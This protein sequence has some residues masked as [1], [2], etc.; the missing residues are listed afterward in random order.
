VSI[1]YKTNLKLKP[2]SVEQKQQLMARIASVL[3]L[4]NRER[5]QTEG[6][7]VKLQDMKSVTPYTKEYAE[8]KKHGKE[9]K[10]FGRSVSKLEREVGA[11]VSRNSYISM[12][13]EAIE[14]SEARIASG[15]EKDRTLIVNMTLTGKMMQALKVVKTKINT[16]TAMVEVGWT[17]EQLKKA[18]GNQDR[19]E[20]FGI[21]KPADKQISEVVSKWSD[22]LL[23]SN[24]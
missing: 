21:S 20:F 6:K 3:I 2:A 8:F 18:A 24:L 1:D 4:E 5:V 13:R 16:F 9:L 14:R 12:R 17:G 15:K 19:R 7:N 11:K 10:K 22:E 23:R